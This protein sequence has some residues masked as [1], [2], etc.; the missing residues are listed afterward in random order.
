MWRGAKRPDR[1]QGE[2]ESP[3]DF[4]AFVITLLSGDWLFFLDNEIAWDGRHH[5]ITG[6][7]L[8]GAKID[9][10]MAF[11]DSSIEGFDGPGE[12]AQYLI[13]AL[14]ELEK[15]DELRVP[16]GS[17]HQ[18]VRQAIR[19]GDLTG[20]TLANLAACGSA[21]TVRMTG[22]DEYAVIFDAR[23]S[24]GIPRF[25]DLV[26]RMLW[27]LRQLSRSEAGAPFSV[28]FFQARNID[29]D[30]Y[31]GNVNKPVTG[32]QGNPGLMTVDSAP[33]IDLTKT[34][35]E[36]FAETFASGVENPSDM[37]ADE[38]LFDSQLMGLIRSFPAT[39]SIEGTHH[40]GRAAR[41]EHVRVGDTLVLKSD[42][43]NQWYS[44]VAIEV[45]N[46][47]GETLGYLAAHTI[48]ADMFTDTGYRGL[49]CL[50]PYITA[51]VESVTPLSKRRKNAKY[52]LM[53]VRLELD[54]SV[55]DANTD[56]FD[57]RVFVEAKK[58]LARPAAGRTA[59]SRTGN[60]PAAERPGVEPMAPAKSEV[61]PEP[62]AA[63]DVESEPSVTPDDAGRQAKVALLRL[64]VLSSELSG[65]RTTFPQELLDELERAEAGDT[66]VDLE[67]LARRMND[68][69]PEPRALDL[70]GVS[71]DEGR[72][73]AGRRFS[74]AVPDG[75]TV[76][77]NYQEEGL[78]GEVLRPFVAVPG[79]ASAD[80][81]VSLYDRVIYS[82]LSGD[83]SEEMAQAFAEC[84]TDDM[85]WAIVWYSLL[86]QDGGLAAFK[87]EIVW[88][89]E[90][91]GANTTCLVT[92]AEPTE[93][94]NG[95]EFAIRP[96]ANDHNDYLRLVFSYD[97]DADMDA[98]RAFVLR[99][100]GTV[101]LDRPVVASCVATREEAL[102]SSVSAE[103]FAEM[104]T[105]YLKSFLVCRQTAFDAGSQHYAATTEG[106]TQ[107]GA[108]LA[109]AGRVALLN[110][111]AGAALSLLLDA[112]DAQVRLGADA[113]KRNQMLESL[114][115]FDKNAF[116]TPET[117]GDGAAV[118][119]RRGVLTE[120]PETSAA[121]QRLADAKS[122]AA[123]KPVKPPAKTPAARGATTQARRQAFVPRSVSPLLKKHLSRSAVA[124]LAAMSKQRMTGASFVKASE[125][126]VPELLDWSQQRVNRE[127]GRTMFTY[128]RD[129]EVLRDIMAERNSLFCELFAYY[130]D[131]IEWQRSQ[132]AGSRDLF[133]MLDEAD[134]VAE[135]V[136]GQ[137]ALSDEG[138]P[139]I[140]GI[141]VPGVFSGVSRR[142]ASLRSEAR[143]DL[144]NETRKRAGEQQEARKAVQKQAQTEGRKNTGQAHES[145][146][147]TVQ[148]SEAEEE[149]RRKAEEEL[150]ALER[151]R[152]EASSRYPVCCNELERARRAFARLLEPAETPSE[153]RA[154]SLSSDIERRRSELGGLG[155]F[156][157]TRKREL[158][159]LIARDEAL[160]AEARTR[161]PAERKAQDKRQHI[162]VN[163]ALVEVRRLEDEKAQLVATVVDAL[164]GKKPGDT[165]FLGDWRRG[166]EPGTEALI[167]WLV[168]EADD[169]RLL[170]ISKYVFDARPLYERFPEDGEATSYE[171]SDL[172]AWL[173]GEFYT[174]A[175]TLVEKQLLDGAPYVLGCDE[176]KKSL[177]TGE[178]RQ[179]GPIPHVS[180]RAAESPSSQPGSTGI[181][182]W[183]ATPGS[184]STRF[185]IVKADGA[186][187]EE[188]ITTAAGVRPAIRVRLPK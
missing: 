152:N 64:L 56:A 76:L 88:D 42:W 128:T 70:A 142:L 176:M 65:G 99:L 180:G 163:Q 57:P 166:T 14:G 144:K 109:G 17:V 33:E 150:A 74:V 93:G 52:A 154:K 71:F 73:A 102:A 31:L 127:T 49:A 12:V 50:L 81:D 140:S 44:P 46:T 123:A 129:Q 112:Y 72:R 132:G 181:D 8:N 138:L 158:A 146:A 156:S 90:V 61:E 35:D 67:D 101:E 58:L 69:T 118:V 175:F 94:L 160:L 153:K 34:S 3:M 159:E 188:P 173:R 143:S 116:V 92:Q 11:V 28:A 7:Q 4:P 177:P 27:D 178:S 119:R 100:A 91:P 134:E 105:S 54:P 145:G 38:D 106:P 6:I 120:T 87:K 75:W 139:D 15:D 170:L 141:P 82:S 147:S 133:R 122:K 98:L 36:A 125:A 10:F 185:S 155:I 19:E 184:F 168:L 79:P 115:T 171:S 162:A 25:F 183:T 68:V 130:L 149:A 111:R 63:P 151:R 182:Y 148:R 161:V 186:F 48:Y 55:H 60:E 24:Q 43:E 103:R 21:I 97:D 26:A 30:Q 23:L 89:A 66:T 41:I 167:E 108:L 179:C 157:L 187:S 29:A 165:V 172:A 131:A 135:L 169:D 16:R 77:E 107:E 45:F 121:R 37:Q 164:E 174:R 32:A 95:V 117:F 84:G 80:D 137:V 136:S 113:Q 114:E 20:I 22:D 104:V 110:A 47:R 83:L 126:V 5:S 53:D 124:E 13:S 1:P 96:Y 59:T 2:S 9:Q 39:I 78:A 18:S 40:A 85:H 86:S 62:A 51:T